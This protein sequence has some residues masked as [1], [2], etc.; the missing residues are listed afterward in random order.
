MRPGLL[1]LIPRLFLVWALLF[2]LVHAET[3]PWTETGSLHA[4]RVGHTATLLK[5]GRV[6]IVGGYDGKTELAGAELYQRDK[7]VFTLTRE[8]DRARTDHTATLLAD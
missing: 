1:P 3:N 2:G 6:L 5:D 7:G 4:P 8:M